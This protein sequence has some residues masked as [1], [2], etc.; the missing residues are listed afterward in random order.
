MFRNVAATNY[1]G[2]W[3]KGR[4]ELNTARALERRGLVKIQK[5]V[6]G[7]MGNIM[8]VVFDI[9]EWK[10]TFERPGGPAF[11]LGDPGEPYTTGNKGKKNG[12]T[13]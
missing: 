1:H 3:V 5:N 11:V 10:K 2:L 13:K 7:T 6:K 4:D 9:Y 12:A 8:I